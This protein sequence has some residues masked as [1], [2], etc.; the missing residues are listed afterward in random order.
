MKKKK[1]LDIDD[2]LNEFMKPKLERFGYPKS[3][4]KKKKNGWKILQIKKKLT[5]IPNLNVTKKLSKKNNSK[6]G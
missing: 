1:S 5:L 6:Q 2:T 3:D 4:E